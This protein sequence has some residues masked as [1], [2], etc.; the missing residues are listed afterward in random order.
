MAEMQTGEGIYGCRN[1]G[2]QAGEGIPQLVNATEQAPSG[3]P[4]IEPVR[5]GGVGEALN[6]SHIFS[7]IFETLPLRG[8]IAVK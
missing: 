3:I 6:L 7:R 4:P 8:H 5:G 2:E 1:A